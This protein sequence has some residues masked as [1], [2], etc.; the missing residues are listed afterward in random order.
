MLFQ[1]G[2][3]GS[4]LQGVH[5]GDMTIE[6][7]AK[8]GDFGIGT[9]NDVNGELIA[10]DGKFYRIPAQGLI[11]TA[12]PSDKTPFAMV[13]FF[14]AQKTFTL[15]NIS[16]IDALKEALNANID[17]KN[18]IYA[19]RIDGDFI[20]MQTR[21]LSPQQKPY[22]PLAEMLPKLQ[23]SFEFPKT[24][25]TIVA[26]F[27][28]EYMGGINV[29]GH[30]LHYLDEAKTGGG[31]VFALE[32]QKATVQICKITNL[33]INLPNTTLFAQASLGECDEV[34]LNAVEKGQ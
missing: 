31:H 34:A 23:K 18:Y 19:I 6:T 32:T 2:T 8:H 4:L 5:E 30:H 14:Q 21:S 24:S 12:K 27:F 17:S 7:L 28:P 33:A 26:I 1:T 9:F 20:N 25:G 15:E 22:R 29:G 16:D 13:T 10:F 3:I 11:E